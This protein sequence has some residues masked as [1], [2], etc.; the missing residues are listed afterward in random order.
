MADVLNLDNTGFCSIHELIVYIMYLI[1]I[2]IDLIIH[3]LLVPHNI[4]MFHLK[5]ATAPHN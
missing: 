3:S 5:A 4:I 1:K 2:C